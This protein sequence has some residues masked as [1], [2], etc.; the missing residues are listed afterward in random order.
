MTRQHR[1]LQVRLED[2]EKLWLYAG[3]ATSKHWALEESL[4][5][6]KSWSRHWERK[7]KES[8]ERT[9]GVEKERDEA[10]EEAQVA[11]LAAF[12]VGDEKAKGEGDLARV[13]DALAAAEEARAVAEEAR[14]KVEAEAA[15][16]E[17]K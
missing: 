3:F 7:A 9:A 15:R 6:A 2:A 11:Q 13:Q 1:E 10:N 12:V 16:L 4:S 8:T 14:R 5:K 17:V